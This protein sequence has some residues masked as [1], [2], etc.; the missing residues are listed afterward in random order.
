[1]DPVHLSLGSH[2]ASSRWQWWPVLPWWAGAFRR[3]RDLPG[4]AHCL[5]N[6]IGKRVPIAAG[7]CLPLGG[8]RVR[9]EDDR[10]IEQPYEG[11]ARRASHSCFSAFNLRSART[12]T[13]AFCQI[14]TNVTIPPTPSKTSAGACCGITRPKNITGR[15]IRTRKY[16]RLDARYWSIAASQGS[17][18]PRLSVSS[19]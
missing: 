4:S 9:S 10:Q 2:A 12:A 14:M 11:S 17:K 18:F 6:H 13:T 19:G 3:Q 5:R 7:H 15:K 1:M 8:R 16:R